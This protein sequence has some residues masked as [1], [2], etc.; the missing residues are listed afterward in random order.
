LGVSLSRQ[1]RLDEALQELL[2]ARELDPLSSIIARLGSLPYLLKRDYG[3]AL[4]QLRQADELGPPF[5]S[6]F[7]IEIYVQNKLEKEALSALEQAKRDREG[8]PILIYSRG[9]VLA[10]EGKRTEAIE[11]IE[12]LEDMSGTSLSEAQWIAKMYAALN[13]KEL[14]LTWLDRGLSTGAVGAFYKDEP[15]W[16]PIRNVPRFA[17]L[18][19]R[20]GIQ[21]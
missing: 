21:Q 10:A 14:A 9:R 4:D 5:S 2:K 3:R 19:R 6:T 12:R 11:V 1:G 7:E 8:D 16:D 15:I 18:L 13:E 20:M 17:D